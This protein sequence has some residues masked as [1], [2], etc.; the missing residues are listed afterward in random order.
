MKIVDTKLKEE[1]ELSLKGEDLMKALEHAK[2]QYQ[3]ILDSIKKM[4][5]NAKAETTSA[6]E[7]E[8]ATNDLSTS[9]SEL[10]KK[11]RFDLQKLSYLLSAV[12]F[13]ADKF[14]VATALELI[15]QLNSLTPQQLENAVVLT[16]PQ[17]ETINN[18]APLV[19]EIIVKLNKGVKPKDLLD[20]ATQSGTLW[21][22]WGS[23]STPYS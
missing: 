21:R 18:I 20:I 17:L 4:V 14:N 10:E 11:V 7:E 8:S 16:Q 23:R 6:K 1:G 2:A 19:K 12:G 15:N 13:V 9:I 5:S 3:A 22:R